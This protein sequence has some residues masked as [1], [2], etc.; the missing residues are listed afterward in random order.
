LREREKMRKT[1]EEVSAALTTK[2]RMVGFLWRP[3]QRRAM[4]SH[5]SANKSGNDQSRQ[6][7]RG[8]RKEIESEKKKLALF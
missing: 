1:G 7:K 8:N 4:H 2:K 3:E 5:H 6:A